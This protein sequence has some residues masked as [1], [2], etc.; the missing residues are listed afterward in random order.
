MSN[1][2]AGP[3]RKKLVMVIAGAAIMV[4]VVLAINV[5]W[6]QSIETSSRVYEETPDLMA[7]AEQ[8]VYNMTRG[9]TVEIPIIVQIDQK[10]KEVNAQI[11][12]FG[13]TGDVSTD[14]FIETGENTLPEGFT[15][16]LDRSGIHLPAA[17]QGEIKT[18]TV[19]LTL[20][21]N[22]EAVSGDHPLSPTLFSYD[23]V[24]NPFRVSTSFVVYIQ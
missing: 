11:A 23:I 5:G 6:Q 10:G 1:S 8:D 2:A 14:V 18:E 15:G 13:S 9:E 3:S 20:T 17:E 12:V 22:D 16:S 24:G 21:A 19:F 7:H 4:G